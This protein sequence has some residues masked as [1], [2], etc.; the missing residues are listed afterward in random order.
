MRQFPEKETLRDCPSEIVRELLPLGEFP[1]TRETN[2]VDK[3]KYKVEEE[4][5]R[6]CRKI[7][8]TFGNSHRA[9]YIY[10]SL[11]GASILRI[12]FPFSRM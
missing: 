4:Q 3:Q 9:F 8:M 5:R 2:A 1:E 12:V 10:G 7:P 6:W 11:W